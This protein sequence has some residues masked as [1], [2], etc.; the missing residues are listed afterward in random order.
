MKVKISKSQWEEI[1]EKAGWIKTAMNEEDHIRTE[2][3]AFPPEQILRALHSLKTREIAGFETVPLEEV[4]DAL[5]ICD[6]EEL[7]GILAFL[8]QDHK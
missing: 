2:I 4:Y 7:K 5:A 3:N 8:K 1:G 6:M